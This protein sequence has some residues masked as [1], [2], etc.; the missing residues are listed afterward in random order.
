MTSTSPHLF[1]SAHEHGGNSD[2][3]VRNESVAA[4]DGAE[5]GEGGNE[6]QDAGH[7][8]RRRLAGGDDSKRPLL[9]PPIAPE[10]QAPSATS[11]HAG[12]HGRNDI[13]E[14]EGRVP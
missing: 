6:L 14:E 11:E 10:A 2:D 1:P 7:S 8:K 12:G 5:A 13:D 9:P 3:V 4:A